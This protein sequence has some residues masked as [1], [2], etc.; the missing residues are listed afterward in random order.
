M[1]AFRT[2]YSQLETWSWIAQVSR[3]KFGSMKQKQNSKTEGKITI[4]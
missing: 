2:G 4:I 1:T 3:Q